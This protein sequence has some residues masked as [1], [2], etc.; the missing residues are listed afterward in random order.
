MKKELYGHRILQVS[1][2]CEHQKQKRTHYFVL[3]SIFRTFVP[4]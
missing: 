4:K 3:L 2:F 1:L